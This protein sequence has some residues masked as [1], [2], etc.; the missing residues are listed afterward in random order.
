MSD[1][2][3]HRMILFGILFL[4]S[5]GIGMATPADFVYV[6]AVIFLV[7]AVAEGI[8]GEKEQQNDR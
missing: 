8:Q 4:L 2:R 3:I 5:M 6:A 7:L 1:N